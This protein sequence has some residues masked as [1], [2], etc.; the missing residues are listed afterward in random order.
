MEERLFWM[1]R[2]I[3]GL[4]EHGYLL[5]TSQLEGETNGTIK[6][7][8]FDTDSEKIIEGAYAA[9]DTFTVS[10][11][12]SLDE[13]KKKLTWA[14][15]V[16]E[17]GY[18]ASELDNEY[19]EYIPE[20]L[21]LHSCVWNITGCTSETLPF[22]HAL[23]D[24]IDKYTEILNLKESDL[25]YQ[26]TNTERAAILISQKVQRDVISEHAYLDI[27]C[28]YN[29]TGEMDNYIKNMCFE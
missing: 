24:T 15:F 9:N 5:T 12:H 13:V 28:S 19:P 21:R 17:E 22:S 10:E 23:N 11:L 6:A 4:Y 25:A 14:D 2:N 7:S 26:Y 20:E 18:A 8:D 1:D 3:E 27:L 29:K 16:F